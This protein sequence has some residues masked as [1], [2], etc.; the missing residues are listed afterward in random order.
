MS[1]DPQD[2]D[3]AQAFRQPTEEM[4][5][6]PSQPPIEN[7]MDALERCIDNIFGGIQDIDRRIEHARV[8]LEGMGSAKS[9]GLG[10]GPAQDTAPA[11]RPTGL[12][13]LEHIIKQ[14]STVAAETQAVL[15]RTQMTCNLVS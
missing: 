2:R 1:F 9:A 4:T 11:P 13:R 5:V 8:A 6:G 7:L 14:A 10:K 12:A 15:E 3:N